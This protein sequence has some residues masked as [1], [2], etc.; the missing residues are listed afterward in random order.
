M[1][2]YSPNSPLQ[3]LMRKRLERLQG[4]PEKLT[5]LVKTSTQVE[6]VNE[7]GF[8]VPLDYDRNASISS[9][10]TAGGVFASTDTTSADHLTINYQYFQVGARVDYKS[11]LNSSKG[12][13]VNA[14]KEAMKKQSEAIA[15]WLEFFLCQGD[16][17]QTIATVTAGSAGTSIACSGATDGIGAYF[18]RKRQVIR[19]YDSTLV[20]LKG[21]RTVTGKTSNAGFDVN[22]A[23]TVVAGDKILIDSDPDAPTT[24]GLKG[25][26]Y[27]IK[28][29]GGYFDK[30]MSTLPAL[31]SVVDTTAAALSAVKLHRN[32]QRQKLRGG[33]RT[34]ASCLLVTSPTQE[35]AYYDII[36]PEGANFR[37]R[38][39]YSGK[40]RPSGD[41]GLAADMYTWFG[42]PVRVFNFILPNAWYYL[43]PQ[44]LQKTEIKPAGNIEGMPAT[45][46]MQALDPSGRYRMAVD[47]WQD[48]GC[49][50]FSPAPHQHGGLTALAIADQAQLVEVDFV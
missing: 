47:R 38:L 20:T 5:S 40:D 19:V 41:V 18:V 22:T 36:K 12:S 6:E 1:N 46:W 39:V 15:D 27:I 7:R 9:A 33:K 13:I 11:I 25:L 48:V 35:G 3:E 29:A 34:L 32:W 14:T 26:P 50:F 30:N 4:D 44:Y 10:N 31:R 28:K 45:D 2:I 42:A 37:E 43:N 23:I 8:R 17:T 16:G 21:T 49:E 24:A